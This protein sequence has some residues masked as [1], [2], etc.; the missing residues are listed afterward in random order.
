MR[1]LQR[2]TADDSNGLRDVE[3][4]FFALLRGDD[5]FAAIRVSRALILLRRRLLLLHLR[6]CCARQRESRA[7]AAEPRSAIRDVKPSLFIVTPL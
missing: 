6:V 1:P 5:D 3:D 4:R 7:R 2:V